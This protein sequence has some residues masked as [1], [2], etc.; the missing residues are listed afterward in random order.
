MSQQSFNR[1]EKKYI[2]DTYQFS[3][4]M[5][6]LKDRIVPNEFFYSQICSVYFDTDNYDLIRKS[7]EKPKYKEKIR[8]RSYGVP[9][10]DDKVFFEIKKKCE[11]VVAKRRIELKLSDLYNY[12]NNKVI[13]KNVNMQIL[14]EISYCFKR[15]NL[16]PKMYIAYDRYSYYGKE[17][18]DFRITFDTNIRSRDYD[19]ALESEDYGEML[20]NDGEYLMEVKTLGGVPI[21]FSHLLSDLKIYSRSFSKYGKIYEKKIKMERMMVNV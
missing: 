4:L 11:G 6:N 12:L 19:L 18:K 10:L 9:N 8:V 16:K 17:N 21:W 1:V 14:K 15:Y 3:K 7:I 2:L 20:L 13:P 5:E